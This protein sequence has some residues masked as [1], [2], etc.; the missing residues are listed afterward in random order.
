MGQASAVS[1][2][3][4]VRHRL[5]AHGIFF[6]T[7]RRI[8][9]RLRGQARD[10][11]ARLGHGRFGRAR[12]RLWQA[13]SQHD[14]NG[15]TTAASAPPP[16]PSTMCIHLEVWMSGGLTARAYL[17]SGRAAA[18]IVLVK[19]W[20]AVILTTAWHSSCNPI[21]CC[22]PTHTWHTHT[23]HQDAWATANLPLF[24]SS[25]KDLVDAYYYRAKSYK[26]HMMRTDWVDIQHVS[27]EFG[28]TVPW[29]GIYGTINAAAGHQITEGRWIRDR[30]YTN[31]LSR[32]WIGS[33]SQGSPG[34]GAPSTAFEP[35]VGHF[36]N[37]TKVGLT[38]GRSLRRFEL[39]PRHAR[40][41]PAAVRSANAI[42]HR[43]GSVVDCKP[44]ATVT[45]I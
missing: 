30:N 29:G 36:P 23:P 41:P 39:S 31:G 9:A 42:P 14:H 37:G 24:D 18:T 26:S 34:P 40:T 33:Q 17:S 5:L 1:T 28:P 15:A 3:R 11:R 16:L 21:A 7:G 4:L 12:L 27:S 25:D 19:G 8:T 2:S 10:P 35:G 22:P 32:F 20:L 38:T 44:R 13:Q 43:Q 45:R 6:G